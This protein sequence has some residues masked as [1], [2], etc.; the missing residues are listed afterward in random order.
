MT[1]QQTGLFEPEPAAPV[2]ATQLARAAE[3]SECGRYRYALGRTWD[4][5]L[6]SVGFV[7]LNPST[8]DADRDDPTI[9]TCMLF[10]R[11]W[12]YGGIVVRNLFA[13][14]TPH[15][16]VLRQADEP[17]GRFNDQYLKRCGEQAKT[18]AAWGTNGGYLG[19]D[20]EVRKLLR[21]YGVLLYHLGLTK[22]GHPKHPLA[23][24]K[25]RISGDTDPIRWEAA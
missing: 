13:L 9:R 4:A 14:R 17:V 8:A 5:T 7:M 21:F 20:V 10:A 1:G 18:I 11:F 24:G 16:R 2:V 25:S 12:G 19:R 23:R 3:F 22:D 6:P 15:P